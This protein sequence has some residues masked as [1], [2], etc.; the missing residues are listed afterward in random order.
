[1]V[2]LHQLALADVVR[3]RLPPPRP[4]N[5][6][7]LAVVS[8]L[9]ESKRIQVWADW[10]TRGAP[11]RAHADSI[12]QVLRNLLRNAALY[13]KEGGMIRIH[14]SLID[15]VYR[16]VCLNTGPGISADDLPHLFRR[17]Y[18]T[19]AALQSGAGDV[20]IGLAIAKELIEAHGGEIG[21]DSRNG[22]T[23]FWFELPQGMVEQRA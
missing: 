21:A 10:G 9:C 14:T 17:F 7:Q 20:G 3:A 23:A 11:V 4:T 22:W 6:D 13:T 18:R 2:G 5:L 15:G 19:Q 1:V 12:A 16:F 8:P